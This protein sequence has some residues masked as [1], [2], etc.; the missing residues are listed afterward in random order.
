MRRFPALYRMPVAYLAAVVIAGIWLATGRASRP[1]GSPGGEGVAGTST[2]SFATLPP[3]PAG[4]NEPGPPAASGS[5]PRVVEGSRR[6]A[7]IRGLDV[8]PRRTPDSDATGAAL[9]DFAVRFVEDETPTMLRVGSRSG[10]GGWVPRDS[11][12]EWDSPLM[13]RPAPRGARPALVLF[14]DEPCA[15]AAVA[16]RPCPDHGGRCPTEGEESPEAAPAPLMG[17]P[18]LRTKSIAGP[19][20]TPAAVH[21]V[22][23]LVADRAPPAAR[24]EAVAALRPLL[25]HIYIA[26]AVDTTASMR[27]SIASARSFATD[28]AGQ[29]A[30]DHPGM[31]LHLALVEYR[32]DAPGYGFRARLTTKFTEPAGFRA[33]ADALA[34][35]RPDDGSPDESVLDGVALCL[36]G[37]PGGVDWPTGRAGELA[38]KL[39]V[40]LGDAPDHARDLSRATALAARARAAG[41]AIAAVRLDRPGSLSPDDQ[42]RFEGQWRTLAE[43]SYR[44]AGSR[45]LLLGADGAASLAASITSLTDDRKA[46]ARAVAA[47]AAAEAEAR[48][49]PYADS[50]GRTLD[51][52]APVLVDL[53]RGEAVPTPRPDP[54]FN[55][56]K[57]PS[58]RRGW[59]AG[60]VGGAEVVSLELL[61]TRGD[62]DALIAELAALQQAASGSA[63]DL[64]DLL[65]V[66]RTAGPNSYF[67][68]DRGSQTFADHLRRRLGLPIRPGGPLDR[69]QSDLLRADSLELATLGARIRDALLVLTKRRNAPDW[70]DPGRTVEGMAAVPY[71]GLDF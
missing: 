24:P 71:D 67:A 1:R 39:V 8:V 50:R 60:R 36:P 54:R 9:D 27:E 41:I 23:A 53:H 17:W 56:R 30:A 6:K 21:E 14:R 29:V 28:L 4:A 52:V 20:G 33:Y 15:A 26:F 64:A 65:A 59:L 2:A 13:A 55:G 57:A 69:T 34:A 51:R 12:V 45:P 42:A 19:G 31:L 49:Q 48:L 32:D 43:G 3:A 38:T 47:R 18:V 40:L 58:I 70:S 68:S 66:G 37:A 62:L 7:V 5:L 44:A 25:N 46:E 10:A 22:A 11:A 63:T 35:L 61:M 16:G